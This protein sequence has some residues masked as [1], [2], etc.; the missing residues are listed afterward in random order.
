MA[1]VTAALHDTEPLRP[2][3]VLDWLSASMRR[4][5]RRVS[6]L[7]GRGGSSHPDKNSKRELVLHSL[8]FPA[9]PALI[10]SSLGGGLNP[11]APEFVP[12]G[13][14]G[15]AVEHVEEKNVIANECKR[16]SDFFFHLLS[17]GCWLHHRCRHAEASLAAL[18][19]ATHISK[20]TV[21]PEIVTKVVKAIEKNNFQLLGRIVNEYPPLLSVVKQ[22]IQTFLAQLDQHFSELTTRMITLKARGQKAERDVGL[23]LSQSSAQVD[24]TARGG[25]YSRELASERNAAAAGMREVESV[26]LDSMNMREDFDDLKGA[27]ANAL[28]QRQLLQEVA[29]LL[30][31]TD[32]KALGLWQQQWDDLNNRSTV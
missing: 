22:A 7:E 11:K 3:K 26:A 14:A 10:Q 23:T 31:K 30:A 12:D 19:E 32:D 15:Q 8:L 29:Q 21:T 28:R 16:E 1:H 9:S 4:L 18:K 6:T 25:S 13:S 17:V 24:L 5:E 2:H 20:A 27:M